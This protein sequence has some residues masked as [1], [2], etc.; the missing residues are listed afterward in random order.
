[1]FR[2]FYDKYLAEDPKIRKTAPW[3]SE[4]L[5]M[6]PFKSTVYESPPS[7]TVTKEDFQQYR[8]QLPGLL[9]EWKEAACAKLVKLI[10]QSPVIHGSSNGR[11][12][13]PEF[14][15]LDLATTVFSCK[16]CSKPLFYPRVLSHACPTQTH[17]GNSPVLDSTIWDGGGLDEVA[18]DP[19]HAIKVVT[20]FGKDPA[21]ATTKE[22]DEY[23]QRVECLRCR[24][25][26]R[27]PRRLFMP[28]RLAVRTPHL[29]RPSRYVLIQPRA[30]IDL[31]RVKTA[32]TQA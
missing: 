30:I 18:Y 8:V 2:S 21:T 20:A 9:Q 27:I 25:D 11:P 17:F 29:V 23:N 31:A 12:A 14:S 10:Q 16:R 5:K 24:I 4:V 19:A 22:M 1:M 3:F 6:E 15:V 28:W 13:T 32:R 7:R 26:L